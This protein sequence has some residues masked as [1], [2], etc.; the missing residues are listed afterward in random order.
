MNYIG[1]NAWQAPEYNVLIAQ[2]ARWASQNPAKCQVIDC[3]QGTFDKLIYIPDQ[4][5]RIP[6]VLCQDCKKYLCCMFC[7]GVARAIYGVNPKRVFWFASC[8]RDECKAQADR[9]STHY[10]VMW[11]SGFEFDSL[12]N[13]V[14]YAQRD[15]SE[16]NAQ[17][18]WTTNM[19]FDVKC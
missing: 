3:R 12:V 8:Q 9:W 5:G 18:I 17:A 15:K 4:G 1:L 7:G 13:P 10:G 6:G 16:Q 2:W 11:M 14:F 19:V